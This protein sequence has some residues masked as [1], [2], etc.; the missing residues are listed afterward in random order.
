MRAAD[1]LKM[2]YYAAELATGAKSFCDNPLIGSRRLNEAGL[3]VKRIQLA[4]QMAD[5]RRR[6]LAHLISDADRAAYQRDGYIETRNVLPEEQLA[7]LRREIETTRFDAWDM[8]QGNSVTRFI[9]LPPKVLRNLPH[10]RAAVWSKPL[11]NGLRYVGSTNGDPLIYLHIVLTNPDGKR[12]ADPQTAF[13]SDTFHQTAKCWLFLYDIDDAEGPF[14]YIPGSHRLTPERLAWER[15]QSLTASTDKNR[16]HAR[17]S[18]RLPANE[19]SRLNY[20]DPVRFAVPG[21]S[22]VVADTH[23]FHARATSE[24]P[25][26]RVGLYG[27]LRRNPFLPWTGLDVFSLPGAKGRQAQIYMG[28]KDLE[29]RLKGKTSHKYAGKVLPTEPSRF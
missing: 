25:S 11:Q 28:Q 8:R 10:L 18:F 26:V 3:H 5:A 2:P 9:P 7:G 13:H 12:K 19:L 29:M 27:S 1:V 17:G 24:R 22:L 15:E 20:P 6:R 21:N 14:T 23:G 4:E 16:L